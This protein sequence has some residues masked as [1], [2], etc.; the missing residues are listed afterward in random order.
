MNPSLVHLLN[1]MGILS[2]QNKE[3]RLKT[4]S[5]QVSLNIMKAA[6]L[7]FFRKEIVSLFGKNL[8]SRR[9]IGFTRMSL[10]STGFISFHAL[11]P[12]NQATLTMAFQI[13]NA[14]P[15]AELLTRMKLFRSNTIES[16]PS[17]KGVFRQQERICSRNI[18]ILIVL[19]LLSTLLGFYTTMR[20][21]FVSLLIILVYCIPYFVNTTLI[22]YFYILVQFIVAAQKALILAASEIVGQSVVN[23]NKWDVEVISIIQ[24]NLDSIRK[25]LTKILAF[26]I[27]TVAI[28]ILG[29]FL[30]FVNIFIYSERV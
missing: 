9:V 13:M 22:A 11:L 27:T 15:N 14:T 28:H 21:N 2:V 6:A 5:L 7:F 23:N 16:F 8:A 17:S 26:P 18:K 29:D 20:H 3:T 12:F 10:F 4:S 19:T 25:S 24:S 30:F 1:L